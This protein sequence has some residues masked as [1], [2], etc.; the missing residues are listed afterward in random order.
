MMTT[1]F[2]AAASCLGVPMAA[3]WSSARSPGR[4]IWKVLPLPVFTRDTEA[5]VPSMK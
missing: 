4:M 1:S 3:S 5:V 2:P